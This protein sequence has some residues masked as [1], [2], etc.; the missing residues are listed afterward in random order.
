MKRALKIVGTAL[1]AMTSQDSISFDAY[2]PGYDA[3]SR[4]CKVTEGCA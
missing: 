4:R 1:D 2:K 3:Q